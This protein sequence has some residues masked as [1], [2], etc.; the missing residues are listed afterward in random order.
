MGNVVDEKGNFL[1]RAKP[2]SPAPR[3]VERK[4]EEEKEYTKEASPLSGFPDAA[5]GDKDAVGWSNFWR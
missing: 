5:A 4:G 3:K 2:G 1:G